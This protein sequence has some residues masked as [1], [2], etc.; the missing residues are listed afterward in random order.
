MKFRISFFIIAFAIIFSGFGA[1]PAAAAE[2]EFAA[3]YV[4]ITVRDDVLVM[5][6]NTTK[7]D[8]VWTDAG[9]TDVSAKLKEFTNMGVTAAF[10]DPATQTTV[11]FISR[12]SSDTVSLFSFSGMSESDIIDYV[13]SLLAEDSDIST[14]V[15]AF[16]TGGI[17]FFR[18]EINGSGNT[19]YGREIIYG[20]AENA[21]MLQFD[22]Y[23]STGAG[24][25]EGFL[26]EVVSG[27]KFTR[28]MTKEEYEAEAA[29]AARKFF[30]GA[31]IF[32]GLMIVLAIYVII[33][34]KRIKKRLQRISDGIAQFKN[35][36][37]NGEIDDSAEPLFIASSTFED[38]CFIKELVSSSIVIKLY[39]ILKYY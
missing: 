11:N 36:R 3:R 33:R 19:A 10:Y 4:N 30:I 2:Y 1:I 26:K 38:F 22:I 24:L 18:L 12:Q 14:D 15:S 34:K 37:N 20:T 28:I 5:T 35:K 21:Q 23:S 27:M 8:P 9:V 6:P 16:E 29:A 25:D 39:I 7:Y 13:K 31:G 17:K 32:F